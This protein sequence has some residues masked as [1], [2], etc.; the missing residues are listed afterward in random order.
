MVKVKIDNRQTDKQ[1]TPAHYA[2]FEK[3]GAYCFAR[4]GR[5]V[6]IP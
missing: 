3:V 4:V 6:G 1:Y 2:L 5:Y